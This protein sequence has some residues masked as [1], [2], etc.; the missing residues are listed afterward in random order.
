MR[1]IAGNALELK[2]ICAHARS[3]KELSIARNHSESH[4]A[5]SEAMVARAT[6]RTQADE[7]CARSHL[8]GL[9]T[10]AGTSNLHF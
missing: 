3:H 6:W 7:A 5:S 1:S 4:G 2:G 9:S 10:L 8:S